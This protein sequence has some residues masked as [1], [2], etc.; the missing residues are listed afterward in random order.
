M[1]ISEKTVSAHKLNALK[2]LGLTGLNSRAILIYG[3]YQNRL[4]M[5]RSH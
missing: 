1:R 5:Q 4:Q 2:K 3:S